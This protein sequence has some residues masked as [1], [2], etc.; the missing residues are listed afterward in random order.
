[1][2]FSTDCIHAGQEPEPATGAIATPIFQT[3]TFV[4]QGVGDH[5]GYEYARTGNPTR[6]A[7]YGGVGSISV[8]VAPPRWLTTSGRRAAL[9]LTPRRS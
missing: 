8:V 9:D 6:P 7:G 3:S 1:M 4:Q 2:G 5:K